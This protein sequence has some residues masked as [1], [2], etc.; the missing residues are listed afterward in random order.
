MDMGDQQQANVQQ[1]YVVGGYKIGDH[2]PG[3]GTV[4]DPARAGEPGV[5]KVFV[6]TNLNRIVDEGDEVLYVKQ[7]TGMLNMVSSLLNKMG[8]MI[9]AFKSKEE[10]PVLLEPKD[11]V[12]QEILT[13]DDELQ[14][15]EKDIKSHYTFATLDELRKVQAH[16]QEMVKAE[17]G[18]KV[19]KERV[20]RFEKDV[21]NFVQTEFERNVAEAQDALSKG[22]LFGKFDTTDVI[23]PMKTALERY[24]QGRELQPGYQL[25]PAQVDRF[26]QTLTQ[27]IEVLENRAKFSQKLAPEETEFITW[28]QH[29]MET[30]YGGHPKPNS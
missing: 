3:V 15:V 16:L 1:E 28:G 14:E 27:V 8:H 26:R 11:E 2:I 4:V 25:P 17:P 24:Y 5:K 29:Q 13:I 21:Q 9:P 18:N 7:T 23:R 20:A 19:L 10:S 30:F 12:S 6:D 22:L